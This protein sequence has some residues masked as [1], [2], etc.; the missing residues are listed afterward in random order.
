ML[1]TRFVFVDHRAN[2]WN[3]L[4]DPTHA[5]SPLLTGGI[6]TIEQCTE[7]YGEEFVGWESPI[8]RWWSLQA[9]VVERVGGGLGNVMLKLLLSNNPNRGFFRPPF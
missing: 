4:G 2:N 8:Q 1:F 9:S 6:N 5:L 7:T 3:R